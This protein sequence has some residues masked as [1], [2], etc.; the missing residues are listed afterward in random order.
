MLADARI[1]INVLIMFYFRAESPPALALRRDH[2][3]GMHRLT[4]GDFQSPLSAY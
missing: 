4:G 2:F 1:G 3:V